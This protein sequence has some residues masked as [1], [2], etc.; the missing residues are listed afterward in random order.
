MND[1]K[2]FPK[3][4]VFEL[5][6]SIF[7]DE[8]EILLGTLPTIEY[9]KNKYK[10]KDLYLNG[11]FYQNPIQ[12]SLAFEKDNFLLK[13]IFDKAIEYIG[14]RELGKLFNIWISDERYENHLKLTEEERSFLANK[15]VIKVGTDQNWAPFEFFKNGKSQGYAI[16][17]LGLIEKRLGISFELANQYPWDETVEK[18]KNKELDMMSL[19]AKNEAR[20]KYML[21]TS[22]IL[23]STIGLAYKKDSRYN[24]FRRT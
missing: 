24:T 11:I 12:L 20:E 3:N 16:D 13:S 4:D 1:I 17:F 8:S 10:L 18:F 15:S 19:V 23:S 21:F 9:Y 6:E 5:L 14:E 22:P 7:L 2:V